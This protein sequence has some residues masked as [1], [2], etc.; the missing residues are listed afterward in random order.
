MKC[1]S[2]PRW[3]IEIS[4]KRFRIVCIQRCGFKIDNKNALYHIYCIYMVTRCIIHNCIFYINFISFMSFS[5]LSH[6]IGTGIWVTVLSGSHIFTKI[7]S[8]FLA[9]VQSTDVTWYWS[10]DMALIS[11]GWFTEKDVMWPGQRFGLQVRALKRD[12]RRLRENF[13]HGEGPY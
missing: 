3:Q 4:G 12:S 1:Q 13:N 9:R 11:G 6:K 5:Y 8:S 10:C 7:H 2:C